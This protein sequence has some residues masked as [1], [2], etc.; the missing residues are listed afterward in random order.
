MI[1]RLEIKTTERIQ[2]VDI[3]SPIKSFLKSEDISSGVVFIY[4]PHTTCGIMINENADPA[5]KEDINTF[6]KKLVPLDGNYRHAEGNSDAHI[7]ASLI[8][9]SITVFLESGSL[10]LG[11]WQGIFL[12][13][14][15]GPRKRSVLMKILS[16][17]SH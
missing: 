5:V 11:T 9:S 12:A 7:K 15:D 17:I 6:L 2:M 1:K 14:F 4:V 16:D 13:E 3:T 8:G 10:V